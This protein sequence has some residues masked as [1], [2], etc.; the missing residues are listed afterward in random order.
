M[1]SV[2]FQSTVLLLSLCMSK[3]FWQFFFAS[4]FLVQQQVA[5]CS[6][7]MELTLFFPIFLFF[8][9]CYFSISFFGF[10]LHI[11][12]GCGIVSSPLPS[13]VFRHWFASRFK[14]GSRARQPPQQAVLRFGTPHVTTPSLFPETK[15]SATTAL[16]HLKIHIL[17]SPLSIRTKEEARCNGSIHTSSYFYFS[18]YWYSIGLL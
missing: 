2:L 4:R 3:H 16:F 15:A 12:C 13:L 7:E 8:S 5:L 14:S 10:Y 6:L 18:L 1:F 17:S 11:S 9:F